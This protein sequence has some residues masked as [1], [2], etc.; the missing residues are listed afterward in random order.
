[1]NIIKKILALSLIPTS[2]CVVSCVNTT[3][4][5]Q[6]KFTGIVY[7]K[8]KININEHNLSK[9][10]SGYYY[11]QIY[12]FTQLN[13]SSNYVDHLKDFLE[14]ISSNSYSKN[15][16]LE[17]IENEYL[18]FLRLHQYY[19]QFNYSQ[20]I[21]MVNMSTKNNQGVSASQKTKK[22]DLYEELKL[23]KQKMTS[24]LGHGPYSSERD[25]YIYS[26]NSK[27]KLMFKRNNL[28]NESYYQLY[29][30]LG[31]DTYNGYENYVNSN[32]VS[33]QLNYSFNK[34]KQK[35]KNF[36][37]N[38]FCFDL[39]SFSVLNPVIANENKNG[40][41]T[42][43][44]NAKINSI[45]DLN[46]IHIKTQTINDDQNNM[47]YTYISFIYLPKILSFDQFAEFRTA[48]INNEKTN[49]INID[50]SSIIDANNLNG[51]KNVYII[52]SLDMFQTL[53]PNY[54]SNLNLKFESFSND[55]NYD[56]FVYSSDN[57]IHS[58]DKIIA[59]PLNEFFYYK[60]SLV[61]PA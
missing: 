51:K 56:T 43:L 3:K 38:E 36:G 52:D 57:F 1:M 47:V 26:V 18:S 48:E 8:L 35:N 46:N 27:I 60:K 19:S 33:E 44:L 34:Y 55:N 20:L 41:N 21:P 14:K 53:E 9:V 11:K 23:V 2:F 7:N 5:N 16:Q 10:L 32:H 42:V 50:L 54:L 30:L 28:M 22:F 49:N 24:E 12:A 45:Y 29:N 17:N 31:L 25:S 59:E 39:R 37:A 40:K 61:I 6:S 13:D 4:S 15:Q 58:L